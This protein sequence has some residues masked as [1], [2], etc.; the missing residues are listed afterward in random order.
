MEDSYISNIHEDDQILE[1]EYLEK[2]HKLESEIDSL[3][4]KLAESDKKI[5]TQKH[6]IENME[7]ELSNKNNEIKNLEVLINFYKKEKGDNNQI[8]E[9]IDKIKNLEESLLV[10]NKKIEEINKDLNE[11]YSINEKLINAL[12][13]KDKIKKEEDVDSD[14]SNDLEKINDTKKFESLQDKIEE[15]EETINEL[16]KD[17]ENIADKYEDKIQEIKK[18]NN[19]YQNQISELEN[20]IKEINQK[21]EIEKLKNSGKPEIEKEIEMLFKEQIENLKNE[22]N[23]EKEKI[24]MIKE[25]AKE[26]RE[27]DMKEILDLE[28]NLEE[29]KEEM[30]LLKKEKESIIQDKKTL[31]ETNKKLIKLNKELE[32]ISTQQ[33]NTDLLLNNYKSIL[34]KKNIE[35]DNLTSKCKEFKETLDQYEKEKDTNLESF[36]NEKQ[37]LKSEL[38]EKNKKIGII[39]RELNELRAKEGKGEADITKISGDPKQK[40]YDE[41]KELKSNL[42][43]KEKENIELNNKLENYKI[44]NKNELEAQNE[45]LKGLIEGYKQNIDNLKEQKNKEKKDF[46]EQLEKLDM[47]MGNCKCQIAAVQYESDRKL[48]NYINYVKKLQRKLESLGFKFKDKNKNLKGF[49]S[50]MKANTMV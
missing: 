38:E 14:D 20:E 30:S 25:K 43:K 27:S 50:F 31:E 16:N 23:E 46:V 21:Y 29:L 37:I 48:I 3:K 32:T 2:I 26:Q 36:N 40:L 35:I 22:I 47:E 13:E 5:I 9:Y 8:Q 42:E 11:Q 15:L 4:L 17:K 34:D 10:K 33:Y 6:Q 41:I 1:S 28:K 39:Y 24:I 7:I 18:E 19:D 12:T 49:G 44:N 45:Y